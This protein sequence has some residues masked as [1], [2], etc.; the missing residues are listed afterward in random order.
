MAK[1]VF[2]APGTSDVVVTSKHGVIYHVVISDTA[3]ARV[4]VMINGEW[5]PITA[6][7]SSSTT[8]VQVIAL[9]A[10]ND[11]QY[12][13]NVTSVSAGTVTTYLE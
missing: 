13:W 6:A 7:I 12:R 5:I 9:D 4:E 3:S 8:A 11:R 2:S 1:Q 10:Q